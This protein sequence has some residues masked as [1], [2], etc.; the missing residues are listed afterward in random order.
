[1]AFL[2]LPPLPGWHFTLRVNR[3]KD[4]GGEPQASRGRARRYA[5]FTAC[6]SKDKRMSLLTRM[7][8][9]SSTWL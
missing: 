5:A 4:P 7:P 9:V 8:P 2:Q 3:M 6:T 1:M